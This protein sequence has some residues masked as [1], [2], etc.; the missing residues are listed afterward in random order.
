MNGTI[1][2]NELAKHELNKIKKK[3]GSISFPIDPFNVLKDNEVVISFSDFDDL[4]GI[5]INDSDNVTVVGINK[6]RPWTRQR[7]TAAHELCHFVKDI[8]K[9]KN[10][11]AQIQCFK[12][13]NS[14]IEKFA[15]RFA[16]CFLMPDFKVKELYNYYKNENGYISFES[17]TYIA[18]YFGVSFQSCVFRL[19][20]DFKF[21]EGD[22]DTLNDRIK[23]YKPESKRKQFIKTTN[24]FL[25]IGNAINSMSYCMIDLNSITGIKFLNDYIYH[26]N[27]IEGINENDVPYI[28]T[29]LRYNGIKSKFFEIENEGIVFTLGNY[30][31][32]KYVL[33][34]KESF[35]INKCK[36]LHK[37][38]YSYVP[39]PEYSGLYRTND[40]VL[41]SGTIQPIS[42][43]QIDDEL[44]KLDKEFD[45]FI[46]DINK[47]STSEY[48]ERVIYFIYRFIKIHPFSDG[49]GRVSRAMLNW[50]FRLIR[51]PPIYVDKESKAEYLDALS[52]ID[53]ENDYVPLIVFVEKR[54][55]HSLSELH[56]YLFFE[57]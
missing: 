21:I 18:E 33:T 20:Y 3:N 10:D 34:T 7:F 11:I 17:I 25:L 51:I 41:L 29:D 13:S 31:M 16:A 43:S 44:K 32:Q 5:I 19:A 48:I 42:Y 47:F 50:M 28:L 37:L 15:D 4:E 49:N 12:N 23:K 27:R 45:F 53:V 9:A 22:Y 36:K 2:P 8:K 52:K 35:S 38:L 6:N 26:D 57:E 30:T 39:Y 56:N 24:D 54:I 46:K 1:T 14:S 40:A 55:I